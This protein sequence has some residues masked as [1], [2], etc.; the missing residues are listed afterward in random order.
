MQVNFAIN[1][2]IQLLL[3]VIRESVYVFKIFAEIVI[4]FT[5]LLIIIPGSF[6]NR[7]TRIIKYCTI[8][9]DL[10]IT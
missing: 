1:S 7:I 3:S 10:N 4:N 8:T 9:Y 2:L 6:V 5:A